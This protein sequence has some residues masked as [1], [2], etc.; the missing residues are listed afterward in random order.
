MMCHSSM[1]KH[2]I[3]LYRLHSNN[4]SRKEHDNDEDEQEDI[5]KLVN[6]SRDAY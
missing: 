6:L 5:K 3:Y 4:N 2:E 1:S